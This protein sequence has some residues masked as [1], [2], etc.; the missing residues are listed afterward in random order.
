ML[1]WEKNE[2]EK[3][4]SETTK[5]LEWEIDISRMYDGLEPNTNYRLVSVVIYLKQGL[6]NVCPIVLLYFSVTV[7]E[8]LGCDAGWLQ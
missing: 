5:A 4:V 1:E 6:T 7:S 2:T 8:Y 3:E